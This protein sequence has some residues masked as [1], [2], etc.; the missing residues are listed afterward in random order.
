M[1][2]GMAI[3]GTGGI[4]LFF[5]ILIGF[6]I[7]GGPEFPV[8]AYAAYGVGLGAFGFLS[9][10]R[11]GPAPHEISCGN[12]QLT[13]RYSEQRSKV[14]DFKRSGTTLRILVYPATLPGGL[15]R[16][17]PIHVLLSFVPARNPITPEAFDYLMSW[18]KVGGLIIDDRPVAAYGQTPR[19]VVTLS[20][21][22]GAGP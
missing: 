3:L 14:F 8:A 2:A 12:G 4:I 13:L 1:R 19:R 17:F 20:G 9:V 21:R 16:P 22:W 10:L 15:P 6:S 11:F 5:T 18:A 7:R